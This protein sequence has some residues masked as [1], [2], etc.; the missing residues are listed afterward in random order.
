M[1]CM[2]VL[3]CMFQDTNVNYPQRAIGAFVLP[4]TVALHCMQASGAQLQGS[5][6][7]NADLYYEIELLRCQQVSLGL[8]CCPDDSYPCLDDEAIAGLE[9]TMAGMSEQLSEQLNEQL[10]QQG[11]G[12]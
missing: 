4:C 9:K 7:P 11:A 2:F 6:P 5:V 12:V 1:T 10:R 8:A 3:H